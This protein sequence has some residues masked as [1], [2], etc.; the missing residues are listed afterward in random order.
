MVAFCCFSSFPFC[1]FL[2]VFCSVASFSTLAVQKGLDKFLFHFLF[3]VCFVFFVAS[4]FCFVCVVVSLL[5]VFFA[6]GL[7]CSVCVFVSLRFLC[8][9][10][11]AS[12][13]LRALFPDV[14]LRVFPM[15]LYMF[16]AVL[17]SSAFLGFYLFV[18]Y[19][20]VCFR[21]S[22]PCLISSLFFG[23]SLLLSF[24]RSLCLYGVSPWWLRF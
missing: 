21:C 3:F 17:A 7:V 15:C 13:A 1:L 22:F 10:W 19:C 12:R 20:S 4:R 8:L 18:N 6:S 24:F 5:F 14:G 16:F 2:P 9:S 23:F 11:L